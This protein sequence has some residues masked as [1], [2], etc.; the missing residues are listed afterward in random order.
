MML[1]LGKSHP[2]DEASSDI[3]CITHA[4][5]WRAHL[6]SRDTISHHSH[7]SPPRAWEI[8]VVTIYMLRRREKSLEMQT[9]TRLAMIFFLGEGGS[10]QCPPVR[11]CTK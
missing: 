8:K 7:I 4:D 9:R 11:V 10:F 5:W 6:V 2:K 1:E 3:R